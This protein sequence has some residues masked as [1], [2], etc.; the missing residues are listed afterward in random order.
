MTL[1]D[2]KNNG[3]MI[4]SLIVGSTAYNL[5]IPTSDKDEG[6]IFMLPKESFLTLSEPIDEVR[7]GKDTTYYELKKFFRLATS[8]NPTVISFLFPYSEIQLYCLPV[9]QHVLNNRHL[10]ISKRAKDSFLGYAI[11]QIQKAKSQ[12]KRINNPQPKER[13]KREDF[14]KIIDLEDTIDIR[15]KLSLNSDFI[16][17]LI[18]NNDFPMRPKPCDAEFEQSKYLVAKLENVANTYRLY[19]YGDSFDCKGIFQNNTIVCQN[20]P[21]EDE[22]NRFV[23][24]LIYNE[25][26]YDN[27]VKEWEQYWTWHNEHN[28]NRFIKADGKNSLYDCKNMMHSFRL[29]YSGI[30]ILKTGEPIIRFDGEVRE[31]LMN[32]RYGK[33]EY[34]FLME[35]MESLIQD[36]KSIVNSS[37]LPDNVDIKNIENL[38]KEC[39]EIKEKYK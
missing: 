9:M 7:N 25:Q 17:E 36:L 23:G 6:G 30:N 33:Y 35:K 13:P 29:L 32:V 4:Y 5:N 18:N 28:Q 31:F 2:I 20:I 21:K 34:Q 24:F 8:C 27:A 19:W 39:Y 38:Y 3:M 26:E 37:I 1:N 15:S 16:K 12:N 11:S 10:F 14:I 22:W